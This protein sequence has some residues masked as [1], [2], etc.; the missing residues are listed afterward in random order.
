MIIM[1]GTASQ[2]VGI[3]DFMAIATSIFGDADKAREWMATPL[4]ALNNISP[5]ELCG[6]AA[7]RERLRQALGKI[8]FGEFA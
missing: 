1:T 3:T 4:P 6:N 5:K 8:E 2:N 7:D